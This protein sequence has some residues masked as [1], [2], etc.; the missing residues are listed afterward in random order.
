MDNLTRNISDTMPRDIS[1][2][3][4]PQTT[5]PRSV[6]QAAQM[7]QCSEGCHTCGLQEFEI[8]NQ[9]PR[10]QGWRF[11]LGSLC[12]FVL[13]LTFALSGAALGGGSVTHQALGG[14]AGLGLGMGTARG[15]SGLFHHLSKEHTWLQP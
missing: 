10:I 4:T 9:A 11:A 7:P 15:I 2:D 13:P 14:I 12:L 6:P 3:S 8:A 5:V 1:R